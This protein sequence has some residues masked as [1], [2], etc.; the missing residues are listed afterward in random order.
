MNIEKISEIQLHN[1]HHFAGLL[2][3]GFLFFIYHEYTFIHT[4]TNTLQHHCADAG[5]TEMLEKCGSQREVVIPGKKLNI[6]PVA[7]TLDFCKCTWHIINSV[8][9]HSYQVYCDNQKKKS[10]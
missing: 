5:L 10:T 7:L 2:I 4:Y 6:V 8:L 1:S 9:L 3:S